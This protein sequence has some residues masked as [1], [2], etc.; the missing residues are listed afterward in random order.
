[1]YRDGHAL[2]D[3]YIPP[4]LGLQIDVSGGAAMAVQPCKSSNI[5]GVAATAS[6]S[7]AMPA[8]QSHMAEYRP[9]GQMV[10][11][12]NIDIIAY[13]SCEEPSLPRPEIIK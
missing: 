7:V 12:S 3:V 13:E 9:S 10:K 8:I 2:E 4:K 5:C 11:R 6:L 1:M